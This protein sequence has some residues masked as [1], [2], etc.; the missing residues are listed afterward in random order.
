MVVGKNK[1]ICSFEEVFF[2]MLGGFFR[3]GIGFLKGSGGELFKS[4]VLR[5]VRVGVI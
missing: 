2:Y 3:G 5:E 1:R 4:I